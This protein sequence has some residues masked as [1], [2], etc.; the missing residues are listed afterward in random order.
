MLVGKGRVAFE[1]FAGNS[2]SQKVHE[3]GECHNDYRGDDVC[4]SCCE[5]GVYEYEDEKQ[6]TDSEDEEYYFGSP[7][8]ELRLKV[9]DVFF[10]EVY[11]ETYFVVRHGI[12][13][14]Y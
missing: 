2:F 13:L 14:F 7:Q 1:G 11:V 6:V 3:D 5:V 8:Q 10:V 4:G 12:F 9:E